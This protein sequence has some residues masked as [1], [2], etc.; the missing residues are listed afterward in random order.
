[1]KRVLLV[2]HKHSFKSAYVEL[3]GL[4]EL[5]FQQGQPCVVKSDRGEEFVSMVR[6]PRQAADAEFPKP[7][8]IFIRLATDGDKAK[9][10]GNQAKERE[11]ADSCRKAAKQKSLDLQVASVESGFD[12]SKAWVYF[13][14]ETRVETREVAKE[15]SEAS[16][17]K[18][19]W[20]QIGG[21]KPQI[22]IVNKS[23][24]SKLHAESRNPT[25]HAP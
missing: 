17:L 21:R 23:E 13:T 7:I 22:L 20:K 25:K 11:L 3:T 1:M 4:E 9:E 15:I 14:A 10:L 8:P 24:V 6:P 18:V 2:R 12:G 16:G 19:E 5:Q